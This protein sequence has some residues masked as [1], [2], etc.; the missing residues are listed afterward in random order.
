VCSGLRRDNSA[1]T[2]KHRLFNECNN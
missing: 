1:R 2:E